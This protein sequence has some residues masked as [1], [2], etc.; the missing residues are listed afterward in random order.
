MAAEIERMA[1]IESGELDENAAYHDA[2]P[3]ITKVGCIIP[4]NFSCAIRR[5]VP[6]WPN[7][8]L[9]DIPFPLVLLL[10]LPGSIAWWMI[11]V[12]RARVGMVPLGSQYSVCCE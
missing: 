8:K 7:V 12:V 9:K 11:V 6:S 4:A 2:V 5:Q 3:A 1:K 10:V